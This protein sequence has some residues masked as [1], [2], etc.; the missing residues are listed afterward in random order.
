MY[1]LGPRLLPS[2]IRFDGGSDWFCLSKSLIEFIIYEQNHPLLTQLFSLYN[3]TLL[4]AE[5][6]F[7]T[8]I[9]NSK[10]CSTY[11][12]NNLRITNW[13]RHIGCQCQH[14]AVVDWCGCSPN[15][16]KMDDWDR[17][18][19]SKSREV[20]FARKFDATIDM[21]VM[22]SIDQWVYGTSV[23]NQ[24]LLNIWHHK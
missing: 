24:F 13:K 18:T 3:Y 23:P 1:R 6:F 2:G 4:P 10:F 21:A 22:N 9:K 5:S 8:V 16:F 7:H 20:F 15:V 14:K 12:N 11:N 19:K 17:I